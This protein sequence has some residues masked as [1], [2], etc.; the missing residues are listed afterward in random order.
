MHEELWVLAEEL[1][2]FNRH[3]VGPI[4]VVAEYREVTPPQSVPS[5]PGASG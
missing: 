3:I 5:L 2:Q 1:D 4:E